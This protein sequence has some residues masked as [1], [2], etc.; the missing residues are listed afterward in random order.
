MNTHAEQ[1]SSIRPILIARLNTENFRS[2]HKEKLQNAATV[3]LKRETAA[4]KAPWRFSSVRRINIRS[5]ERCRRG[6]AEKVITVIATHKDG[7]E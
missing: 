4:E 5:G 1:G 2:V 6:A 7:Y 3:N